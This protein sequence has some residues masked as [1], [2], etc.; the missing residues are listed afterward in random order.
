MMSVLTLLIQLRLFMMTLM[1]V[2]NIIDIL[3]LITMIMM[4]STSGLRCAQNVPKQQACLRTLELPRTARM[5][6]F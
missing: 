2:D 5:R 6:Y 3:L 1:N 4:I